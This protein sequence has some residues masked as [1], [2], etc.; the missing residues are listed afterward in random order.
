[1]AFDAALVAD[2]L[3]PHFDFYH[4][5]EVRRLSDSPAS[6]SSL[7]PVQA[8]PCQGIAY[9][10]Y[11]EGAVDAVFVLLLPADLDYSTYSELGNILASRIST[12]ISPPR[13]LNSLQLE[14]LALT[15]ATHSFNYVHER[16]N[17][18]PIELRALLLPGGNVGNA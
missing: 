17:S 1:M 14:T 12:M 13:A 10:L 3:P 15:A 5:G 2:S 18:A 16:K 9:D 8:L 6:S 7:S 11:A 4:L